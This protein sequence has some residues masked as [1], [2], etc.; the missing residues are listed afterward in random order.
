[1]VL[2]LHDGGKDRHF[3]CAAIVADRWGV[4]PKGLAFSTCSF[5]PSRAGL[6]LM[7]IEWSFK[8]PRTV[9]VS[10]YSS[11]CSK[12]SVPRTTRRLFIGLSLMSYH[13]PETLKM[14]Y[15]H[16]CHSPCIRLM[17]R[18]HLQWFSAY[19]VQVWLRAKAVVSHRVTLGL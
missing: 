11:F 18:S 8:N 4:E 15:R 14:I 10:F 17:L 2:Q 16:C 13:Q 19:F 3:L 1:M 7:V 5:L 6:W 12:C 9:Q